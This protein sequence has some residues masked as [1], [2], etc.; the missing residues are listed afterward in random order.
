MLDPSQMSR[1]P[2]IL[3]PNRDL[4]RFSICKLHFKN[5]CQELRWFVIGLPLSLF[6]PLPFLILFVVI[7]VTIVTIA[8]VTAVVDDD[9]LDVLAKNPGLYL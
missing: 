5:H 2:N 3:E 6:L 9:V 8:T 1:T 7:V 4:K